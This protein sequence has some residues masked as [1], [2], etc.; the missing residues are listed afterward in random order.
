M[1][2]CDVNA[3]RLLD[4]VFAHHHRDDHYL[5]RRQNTFI[6][7]ID[8][9]K[10]CTD[11]VF[12]RDMQA[13]VFGSDAGRE[14]VLYQQA[15]APPTVDQERA[16]ERYRVEKQMAF[17]KMIPSAV[18]ALPELLERSYDSLLWEATARRCYSC[19]S[20]NLSC[21]TCYCF[22]TYDELDLD[23]RNGRRRREWDGCQ[24]RE[25]AAVA[26]GHNFR[27]QPASRLRHRIYRKAKWVKELEGL[28]GCVG[29]ARCDRACTAKISSVE[30]YRQLAEER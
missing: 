10:P 11:G 23:L 4:Q 13:N 7:A 21:P 1:H 5:A 24:L 8:C 17:P 28:P 22:N 25:F 9:R 26:G 12:C 3:I 2:P 19:G 16:Y 20:C 14:W 6:V 27:S 18:D 29:C 30:I 15:G